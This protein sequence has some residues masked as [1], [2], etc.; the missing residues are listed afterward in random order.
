MGQHRFRKDTTRPYEVDQINTM[1]DLGRRFVRDWRR[2]NPKDK[3]FVL[4][5]DNKEV[6]KAYNLMITRK[7]E[8]APEY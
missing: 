2:A 1:E 3:D 6:L 5:S 4:M 7:Y 8:K